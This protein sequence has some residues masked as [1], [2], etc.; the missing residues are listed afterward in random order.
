MFAFKKGQPIFIAK[1]ASIAVHENHGFLS[2]V[3]KNG[4]KMSDAKQ[5]LESLHVGGLQPH[6]CSWQPVVKFLAQ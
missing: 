3:E 6:H 1:G 2:N 5:E 4:S